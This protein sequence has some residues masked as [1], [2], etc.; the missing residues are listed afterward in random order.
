MSDIE[1]G[2]VVFKAKT[3]KESIRTLIFQSMAISTQCT[4]S[5]I[6]IVDAVVTFSGG[7]AV[8]A[9]IKRMKDRK[10]FSTVLLFSPKQVANTGMEYRTFLSAMQEL[11]LA[12]RVLKME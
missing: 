10:D 6:K 8:I 11:G 4:K 1:R 7:K 5:D 3:D 12:V 9:D 2:I